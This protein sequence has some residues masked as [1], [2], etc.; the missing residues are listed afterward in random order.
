MTEAER[1]R[2]QR[3]GLARRGP[4]NVPKQADPVPK[5]GPDPRDEEIAQL[6][7]RIAE[8]EEERQGGAD[9]EAAIPADGPATMRDELAAVRE[10]RDQLRHRV[11]QRLAVLMN[12][13]SAD[14]IVAAMQPGKR[15]EIARRIATETGIEASSADQGMITQDAMMTQLEALEPEAMNAIAVRLLTDGWRGE[16][17][18]S[19]ETRSG[20][21]ERVIE[22]SDD[23]QQMLATVL[24]HLA[25]E[26][27]T[28]V[29]ELLGHLCQK[30]GVKV[31]AATGAVA[32]PKKKAKRSATKTVQQTGKLGDVVADA[33]DELSRLAEEVRE[34][35]DIASEGPAAATQRIQTLEETADELEGIDQPNVPDTLKD[36]MVT[37]NEV[38]STRKGRGLS[39]ANQAG[40][41]VEMLRAASNA[42]GE[43]ED[44]EALVAFRN[45]LEE[46]AD[47]VDSCE[48][49]GMFG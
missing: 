11:A 4:A 10:E 49:P 33:F 18:C 6:K 13:E 17:D 3:A 43:S 5:P 24:Q 40:A 21:V 27:I 37:Y 14:A 1:K 39:R 34:V 36:L 22:I 12:V 32:L 41:A 20:I 25:D 16:S 35:V 46:A 8:L 38:Q 29:P 44:D 2:R 26:E 31:D 48:F 47:T 15:R 45:A 9:A 19:D 42:V 7:A 30:F 23:P 28:D